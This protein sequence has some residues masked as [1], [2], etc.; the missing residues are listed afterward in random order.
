MMSVYQRDKVKCS[1]MYNR[2]YL[3]WSNAKTRFK[4]SPCPGFRLSESDFK[5]PI[6][7]KYHFCHLDIFCLI[8]SHKVKYGS[9][10]V[11]LNSFQLRFQDFEK[12]DLLIDLQDWCEFISHE[13]FINSEIQINLTSARLGRNHVIGCHVMECHVMVCHVSVRNPRLRCS[14]WKCS[15][16]IILKIKRGYA[17]KFNA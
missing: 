4:I 12:S 6:L 8:R 5:N 9:N 13:Y 1:R 10:K 17:F 11:I 15:I 7:I 16:L 14:I 3:F 2:E